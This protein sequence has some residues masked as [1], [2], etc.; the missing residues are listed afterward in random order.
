MTGEDGG[1]CEGVVLGVDFPQTGIVVFS[2][3]GKPV[4]GPVAVQSENGLGVAAEDGYVVEGFG[5]DEG[6]VFGVGGD[7]DEGGVGGK[8]L[9]VEDLV[10]VGGDV[11]CC[12]ERDR[13][14][15][16]KAEGVDLDSVVVVDGEEG[17]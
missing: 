4:A 17:C 6:N 7:G 12:G 1:T 13:G 2:S 10:V 8:E 16:G 5:G 9:E 15:G 3:G 11:L 14:G